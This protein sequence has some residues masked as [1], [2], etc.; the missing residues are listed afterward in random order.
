MGG[1]I[2]PNEILVPMTIELAIRFSSYFDFSY[3]IQKSN[4]SHVEIEYA[5]SNIRKTFEGYKERGL[6]EIFLREEDYEKVSGVLREVIQ[7]KKDLKEVM[8]DLNHLYDNTRHL[9]LT[10]GVGGVSIANAKDT[11]RMV[12]GKIGSISSIFELLADFK[13]ECSDEFFKY[14]ILSF[15]GTSMIGTFDW[16]S[17]QIKHKM[18][19]AAMLCDLT[20]TTEDY[21]QMSGHAYESWPAHCRDHP[22]KI[23]NVI[24]SCDPSMPHEVLQMIEQHHELPTGEGFPNNLKFSQIPL[25]SAVFIVALNFVDRYKK[26]NFDVGE[27]EEVVGVMYETFTK[28]NFRNAAMALF[29]TVG[30]SL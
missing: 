2:D 14:L 13:G 17:D 27:K 8:G 5:S 21:K 29:K 25:L 3:F 6:Q 30:V 24:R 12:M 11:N 1:K 20:L 28:G 26:S 15:I 18:G 9:L 22:L 7:K 16:Q 4:G 23:A 19:M 10:I